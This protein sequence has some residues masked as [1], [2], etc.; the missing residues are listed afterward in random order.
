L[1]NDGADVFERNVARRGS[2]R[3]DLHTDGEFLR[4][5]NDYL[6]DAGQLRDLWREHGFGVVVDRRQR[7]SVRAHAQ[8]E[9]RKVAGIDLAEAWRGCHFDRQI[10]GCRRQGRLHVE[11]GAIDIA[12]KIELDRYL[13]QPERG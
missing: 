10:L 9:H 12:A 13:R 11:R 4:A 7:H 5:V 2:N 8:I 6:R 3:I 1:R